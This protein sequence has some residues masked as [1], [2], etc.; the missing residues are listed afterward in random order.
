MLE[1]SETFTEQ[2][3]RYANLYF[4]KKT[5][6]YALLSGARAA[7]HRDIFVTCGCFCFFNGAFDTVS[8]EGEAQ[9]FVLSFGHL[10]WNIMRKY[11]YR[12]LKFVIREIPFCHVVGTS[13]H[14]NCP[15]GSY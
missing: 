10:F 6:A 9:P 5:S 15:G 1:Q 12:H 14:Y 2:P 3:R 13:A 8:D 7:Y 11:K 4:V